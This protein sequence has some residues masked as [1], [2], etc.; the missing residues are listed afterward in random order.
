MV[1]AYGLLSFSLAAG[2][3]KH[4]WRS[5]F[6]KKRWARGRISALGFWGLRRS[7]C[8]AYEGEGSAQTDGYLEQQLQETS[9]AEEALAGEILCRHR[10]KIKKGFVKTPKLAMKNMAMKMVMTGMSLSDCE[11]AYAIAIRSLSGGKAVASLPITAS[12]LN[13]A[14]SAHGLLVSL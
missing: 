3:S 6:C 9:V 8:I 14:A 7:S 13:E 10:A 1:C 12:S 11:Q 5:A 4:H 2:A